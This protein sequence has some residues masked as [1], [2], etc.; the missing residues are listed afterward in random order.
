MAGPAVPLSGPLQHEVAY[1]GYGYE[2]LGLRVV[3][4]KGLPAALWEF[5]YRSEGMLVHAQELHVVAGG[6]RYV[7]NTRSPQATW[8]K[9]SGML[10]RIR[11]SFQVANV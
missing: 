8:D 6:I 5:V 10:K 2:R 4:F 3:N 1:W 7:V 9:R 11:E